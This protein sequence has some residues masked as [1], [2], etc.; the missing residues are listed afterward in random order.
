MRE[1]DYAPVNVCVSYYYDP[2]TDLES[3][4]QALARDG[5]QFLLGKVFALPTKPSIHG[6]LAILPPSATRLPR[7]KPLPKPKPMSK[8]QKFANT[9]GIQHVKRDKRVFDEDKQEWVNRWG[10]DGK[11]KE[12]EKQWLHEIPSSKREYSRAS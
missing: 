9:K 1:S 4:L 2:S 8:W 5:V 10:K 3:H 12:I 7:S 6:P 11:N